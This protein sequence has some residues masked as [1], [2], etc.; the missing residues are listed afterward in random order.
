M[1][2]G[3]GWGVFHVHFSSL[4]LYVLG[5]DQNNANVFCNREADTY[6]VFIVHE[7]HDG[8]IGGARPKVT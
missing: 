1:D 7:I 6:L 4:V 3:S 2:T 8:G 5:E